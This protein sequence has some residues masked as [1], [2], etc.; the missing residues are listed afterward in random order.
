VV[1]PSLDSV[2]SRHFFLVHAEQPL[3]TIWWVLL[4]ISQ[5]LPSGTEIMH[6][7]H[8]QSLLL[9]MWSWIMYLTK[10]EGFISSRKWHSNTWVDLNLKMAGSEHILTESCSHWNVHLKSV[11]LPPNLEYWFLI[12]WEM[13]SS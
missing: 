13:F 2:N 10:H 12:P 7:V 3:M 6:Y 4:G 8:Y 9:V 1:G 11:K 5:K